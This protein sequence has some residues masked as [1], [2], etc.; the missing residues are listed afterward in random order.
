MG[1]L[2]T[3]MIWEVRGREAEKPGLTSL[4][5]A[6]AIL[7]E[8]RASRTQFFFFFFVVVKSGQVY[9]GLFSQSLSQSDENC[10]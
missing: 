8:A 4:L 2:P 7:T 3:G 5:Q 1:S 10:L 9:S 6:A